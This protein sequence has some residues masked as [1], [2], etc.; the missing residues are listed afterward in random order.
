MLTVEDILKK[1]A[2]LNSKQITVEQF[3]KMLSLVQ[4]QMDSEIPKPMTME[5]WYDLN[6][7]MS[8]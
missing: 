1:G 8:I 5:Q 2:V 6:V 4:E 3:E 7:P